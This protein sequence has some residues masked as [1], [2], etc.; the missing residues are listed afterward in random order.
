M[1]VGFMT[2]KD[3]GE[4]KVDH[5]KSAVRW[6]ISD[7]A[8]VLVIVPNTVGFDFLED[9]AGAIC[10]KMF[11]PGSAIG[12]DDLWLGGIGFQQSGHESAALFFE[13]LE[14]LHFPVKPGLGIRSMV[15]FD[16]ASIVSQV[17]RGS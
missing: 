7:V 4:F 12:G 14:N 9:F 11:H 17:H 6:T 8:H 10:V 2:G 16:D 3:G 13:K 15:A 1:G 5:A